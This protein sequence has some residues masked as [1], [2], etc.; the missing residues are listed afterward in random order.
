MV[1]DFFYPKTIAI[2]G[3]TADPKKFGNAVTVNLV[4]NEQLESELFPVNPKSLEILGLKSYSTILDIDKEIDLAIILVPS[5]AVPVVVDECIEKNVRRIIIVSAGFGE[6]N[7][8]GK[9][10]EQEMVQKAASKNIRIIGPNCVGIMN[11]D[12]GMNASFILTPPKG[13]VSMVTQSGSF[14]AACLYEMK[15]QGLGFSKF[16]NLGNMSDINLSDLLN[17]YLEDSNSE[18]VCI[19]L[20]NVIDG[21]KFYEILKKVAT[22][23]P[24][25]ILKGGRTAYGASAAASHTGSIA[26]DYTSLQAAI[27]QSGATLCENL[28]DYVAAIKAFSF[29]PLPEGNR[30]GIL[31]NSGGSAV[32]F[33]DNAEEFEMELAE[34]SEQFKQAIDPHVIPLVK[35]VNPLDLIA[36]ANGRSYY[37]VTK[38]MLEDPDIDIVVPCAVIPTFL[39]MTLDEHFSGVIKAWNETGRKKPI[40]PI[41][42]SGELVNKS[43]EIAEKEKAPIFLSPREAA[44]AVKVL[45]ERKKK[46]QK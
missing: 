46:I 11:V 38:A 42:M 14:G 27:K 12:T 44:F 33:S 8:E 25:I 28:Y 5:K 34:F 7:E 22:R 32:L 15:N 20:E 40:I 30:V 39:G 10:L 31:T 18:V 16:A 26:T 3:A 29:L 1:K 36:G 13:N 45:I 23:K 21:R 35:K 37:E 17:F 43:K 19:Y 2:I 6:I 41:F 9:K 24:T 4:E